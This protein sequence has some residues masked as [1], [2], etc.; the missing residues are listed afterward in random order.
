M[1]FGVYRSGPEF[2][3]AAVK[4]GHPIGK[5]VKVTSC[6]QRRCEVS[7]KSLH[8]LAVDRHQT[9]THWLGRAK[10]L[11]SA[12]ANLHLDLPD[13]LR[14]ILA[15]KRLLLWK[16]MLEH[17]GYPDMSVFDEVI[18]GTDLVGAVPAVPEFDQSFKP[19]KMTVSE[20]AASAPSIRKSLLSSI[21]SSGDAEIDTEVYNKTMDELECGWLEGPIEVSALPPHAIINRRFG[22]KQSSGDSMKIRLID[23]FSA[24]GVNATVQVETAP[25]LHTLDIVGALL[26]ELLR[27]GNPEQLVGKTVDL[28]KAYRQLGI[29]PGSRWVAYVAVYDPCTRSPKIFSM[30]A[31]PFGA[32]RSVY[33]FLRVAHSLWWLGAVAMDFVW[34]S[35]FDD[36]VTFARNGEVPTKDIAIVQFFKLLGWAT[37]SGDK[38]LPFGDSFK[39]LG[40][41]VDLS[42]W[43]NGKASFRNTTKRIEELVQTITSVLKSNRLS[44]QAALS[45]RGRMQFAKSQIWGRAAKLCLNAVTAHAHMPDCGP[46]ADGLVS[47]L[48]AFRDSLQHSPPRLIKDA[49]PGGLGGVLVNQFGCQIAALSLTLTKDDLQVLGYPEKSTVIFEAEVLAIIVCLKADS[50]VSGLGDWDDSFAD[51]QQDLFGTLEDDQFSR[52]DAVENAFQRDPDDESHSLQ[53]DVVSDGPEP[54]RKRPLNSSVLHHGSGVDDTLF[55]SMIKLPKTGV[56]RQPWET[57]LMSLVCGKSQPVLSTPWLNLPVLGKQESLQGLIPSVEPV[58]KVASRTQFHYKRLL[59]VRLAQTDDQLRAKALRRLRDLILVEPT[60][61]QLGRALLDTSGQLTGEDRISSV[62]AD[63]FRSRATST[64]VKRSCDYYKMAVW[65]DQFLNLK[66][67]RLTEG[68]VYQY[69][70]FLRESSAAPTS[71]DATVKSIWFMHSTA[72]MIDFSPTMFTSRITGVCR[73][74][75]M[76]KRVL[77]Q[78]PSFPSDVVR[79]LEEYAL[80]CDSKVDSMF[81]NFILFCIYSSCR[82]GD[83]SKIKAVEFSQCHDVYLVE[84]ASTESKNTNTMERRRMLLPF[85]AVGWG[86]HPN[87]WSIKWKMQLDSVDFNTIMPAYSEVSGQFLDR[88]LT[89]SEANL[90]LKEIL[91]RSG[92]STVQAAKFSTHSCKAT[93]P[94][95]ASKFGGFSLEDRKLL[96]HHMDGNTA[97]PLTYSRDNLTALHSRVFRMLTAI[98]NFEFNPDDSN[99]KRIFWDNRDICNIPTDPGHWEEDWAASESDISDDEGLVEGCHF[100]GGQQVPA[101]QATGDKVLHRE[102]HVVHIK[103]DQDTLWCGRRMSANYRS[104]E[105]GDP[106]LSQLLVCQQCDRSQP[107]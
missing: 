47:S 12:E 46:L 81:T 14:H 62:F 40:V 13:S 52:V 59:A 6:T 11:A 71:A 23:D 17:Y 29:A 67:M 86:V 80:T 15:P 101:D 84:A 99:A 7:S 97:M 41:E 45:L 63:A 89:T 21:R 57:G 22:I 34:S 73:D 90:W 75:Y 28:S 19:E 32:S 107:K 76:R 37:S 54:T 2:V 94:T 85:T 38:D 68:I 66:P 92:L 69:L 24:S 103:R 33:S 3:G 8:E 100:I 18:S 72:G 91:V 78:A 64:L 58:E 49:W 50:D 51:N 102:S 95:W 88:R 27:L 20:L 10:E 83:A 56:P 74:M 5:E 39:D 77:K 30:R 60:Q 55:F 104:W 1:C 82:I 43:K 4:A 61:S 48:I 87:P 79:S 44:A 42:D 25:K 16:G 105:S 35:F 96:T 98:R 93:I 65:M 9:L 26:M 31:L 36:F 53:M 70:S 106:E